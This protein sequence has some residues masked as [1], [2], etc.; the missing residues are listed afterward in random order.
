MAC[1]W[2]STA[3]VVTET[4]IRQRSSQCSRRW[5]PQVL[6]ALVAHAEPHHFKHICTYTLFVDQHTHTH[7][8]TH[9]RTL[10]SSFNP[11]TQT[12]V[13]SLHRLTRTHTFSDGLSQSEPN[14]YWRADLKPKMS[15]SK[16]VPG[17]R[18]RVS[19]GSES[20]CRRC[21]VQCFSS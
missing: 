5:D 8:H 7:T 6:G 11:H 20:L 21:V 3:G 10:S 19:R 12:H 13:Y 17:D 2:A 18:E 1:C 4:W 9:T 16:R 14:D 15:E